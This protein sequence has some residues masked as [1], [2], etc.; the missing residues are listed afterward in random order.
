MGQGRLTASPRAVLAPGPEQLLLPK[1]PLITNVAISPQ[2]SETMLKYIAP[3]LAGATRAEGEF[4]LHL[5]GTQIPLGDPRQARAAGQLAVHRLRISPG[6]MVAELA[7][8]VAKIEALTKRE[9][10]RQILASSGDNEVLSITDRQVDFQVA[11]GRV[12]HRDL[13][14]L[15]D[16]VPVRSQGSVGFDQ[17]LALMIE[18]PIQNKWVEKDRVL[19]SLAGETLKIPVAGT[20]QRPR[21][22]QRAVAGLSQQLLQGAAG[23]AIGDEINRQLD[24]LL[25]GR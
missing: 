22:D 21:I 14:F 7:A 17:S 20:F 12:Y 1:G 2:V 18:V 25:R 8:L 5:E 24:K 9:R 3:V 16:D 4:S 6:P 11:E 23:Q 13:E 19:R 15:I 10:L